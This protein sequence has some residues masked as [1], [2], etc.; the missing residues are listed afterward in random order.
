MYAAKLSIIQS[1]TSIRWHGSAHD[2]PLDFSKK[3][4][5]RTGLRD[6]LKFESFIFPTDSSGPICMRLFSIGDGGAGGRAACL[7]RCGIL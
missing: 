3:K 2:S 7:Q 4:S 6:A 5:A 1:T